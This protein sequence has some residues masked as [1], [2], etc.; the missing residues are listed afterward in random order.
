MIEAVRTPRA[1]RPARRRP[2]GGVHLPAPVLGLR[3][4]GRIEIGGAADIVV[5]DDNLRIE[6][7][8]VGG[9]NVSLPEPAA[10]GPGTSSSPR[11]TSSP[12][13]SFGSS[14]TSSSTPVSRRRR[15][16]RGSS[17][18]RIVARI[19]G[20]RGSYGV[21]AFGL[22]PWWTAFRDSISSP[23]TT[24]PF[25]TCGARPRSA[26]RNPGGRLTSSATSRR[27]AARRLHDCAH[28]RAR[29]RAGRRRRGGAAPR[30]RLGALPSRR[31]RRT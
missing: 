6:R 23:S 10:P 28:Q 16:E 20:Q 29:V 17:I 26:S 9:R 14:T 12:R 19:V 11:S 24:E 15:A 8:L 4:V 25:S 21:Y 5:V 27:R 31:R 13:R 18:V 30:R 2:R 7:V 22:M 1:R 3:D